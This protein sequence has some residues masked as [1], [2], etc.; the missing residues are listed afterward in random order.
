[1]NRTRYRLIFSRSRGQ[2]MA[3]AETAHAHGKAGQGERTGN[4]S[5]ASADARF[6]MRRIA[7]PIA[8][9]LC[10]TLGL[11]PVLAQIIADSNAPASQQPTVLGDARS[12]LVNIQTPSAAGVSRNTYSQFDV[13]P[14]GVVLNNSHYSNPWLMNGEARVILNEVNSSNPSYLRG[15]ITVNGVSAQ[16]VIAN[17]SGIQV[18]GASFVNA[19]RATLTTG[20]PIMNNGDLSGFSVRQGAVDISGRGLAAADTPYTEILSRAALIA[21]SVNARELNVTTGTQDIDYI[22]GKLTPVAGDGEPRPIAIDTAMLGGMYAGKI[23]LLATESGVGVR[24]AGT[25]SAL[26]GQIII[27]ADGQLQNTGS[28]RADVTSLATVSGNIDNSGTLSGEAMLL[29]AAAGDARFSG[30]QSN[31][32]G[33]VVLV[34]AGRDILFDS[35]VRVAGSGIGGQIQLDA[36]RNI[37]LAEDGEIVAPGNVSLNSG[38]TIT[39]RHSLV[40]SDMADVTVLA[41]GGIALEDST[42]RG[43][44]VHLETGAPFQETATDI[45]VRGGRIEGGQQATLIA[46]RD[47][48]LDAPD[49]VAVSADGDVALR[50]GGNLRMTAGSISTAG[51]DFTAIAGESLQMQGVAP[52]T[53][54][55]GQRAGISAIGNV[56][57]SGRGIDLPRGSVKAGGELAI[58]ATSADIRLGAPAHVYGATRDHLQLAAMGDLNISAY[59]GGITATTLD[60]QGKNIHVVS[61]GL[62]EFST[63]GDGRTGFKGG[64][65]FA[66]EDL[67]LGSISPD[68]PLSLTGTQLSAGGNIGLHSN[69]G[70]LI[71]N[72]QADTGGGLSGTA[73]H[74]GMTVTGTR[75]TAKGLL[76][77]ASSESQQHVFNTYDA[78]AM[79]LYTESGALGLYSSTLQTRVNQEAGLGDISGRLSLEAGGNFYFNSLARLTAA[80]DLSLVAGEGNL[81]IKPTNWSGGTLSTNQLSVGRDLTLAARHGDLVLDG[82]VG[83]NGGGIGVDLSVPRNLA[84]VGDNISMKGGRLFARTINLTATSGDIRIDAIPVASNQAGFDNTYWISPW[85]YGTF[86]IDLQAA[87]DIELNSVFARSHDTLSILSGGNLTTTGEYNRRNGIYDGWHKDEH[88]LARGMLYGNRGVTLGALGGHL[89]L[90]A[91]DVIAASGTARLQALGDIVLEAAQEHRLWQTQVDGRDCDAWSWFCESWTTYYHRETLT[92]QPVTVTARDIELKAGG[93]LDTYATRLNAGGNLTLEAGEAIHYYAVYDQQDN[94]ESR[95]SKSSLWGNSYSKSTESNSRSTLIGQAT[96][97][98]SQQ[99]ILSRS[100]GDQLLQGTQ[101]SYGGSA[102]FQAGVG[103]KPRADARILLEGLKN[104]VSEHRTLEYNAVLWQKQLDQGSVLETLVLP[105]FSGPGQPRFEAPG[106][107]AAQLPDASDFKAQIQ[108]LARQPGLAY[109]DGLTQRADVNWQAVKL[110]H[111][112][113]NYEQEGLTGAGAALL[114]VVVAWATAGLG[115]GANLIGA[116]EGTTA[117]LMADAAFTSLASQAAI[118]FVNN[119]GDLGKTLKD[120]GRSET[121]K[122][123]LAAMLT[124]GALSQIDGLGSV[125]DLKSSTAFGDQLT[126]NLIN[127]GGRAL[128]HTAIEGGDLEDALKQAILGAAVDTLHGEAASKIKTLEA[129]YLAH[130]LAH[131]LAGCVAGAAANGD[132]RDGAIGAAVGEV[133][134]ELMPPANGIAYSESE[135]DNVL[136]LSKLVAGATSAYAGGDAQTAITTAETAV[137]NNALIPVIVGLAW[138]ADKAWTAYEVSQDL[139]AIRDGT[140]TVAQVAQEKGEDYVTGIILGNIG[141]YGVKA[142]KVGGSWAQSKAVPEAKVLISQ[143]SRQIELLQMFDP[144]NARKGITVDNRSLLPRAG[145]AVPIYDGLS[146]KQ[147]QEYFKQL[148]G[149]ADLP[150]ARVIPGKGTIYQAKT[151]HG[152]FS[153]RDFADTASQSGPV[154]TIDFPRSMLP[155]NYKGSP[156]IK[157]GKM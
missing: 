43:G 141:R 91:T 152:N 140:K 22:T 7:K 111:D 157:F 31:N 63:A 108:T 80:T 92:A 128:T 54:D 106:G 121:V 148:T 75:L 116:T 16:V 115:A 104:S 138:L 110:A 142:V 52:D 90:N 102:T 94:A 34:S 24:N 77:L 139:A 62:T 112:Q 126:Y 49:A 103:D 32:Q 86:G 66:L 20:T 131:A 40:T 67:T 119:K 61:N 154:W 84:L 13:E 105:R 129:D 136:A 50:A 39:L 101:V 118:S 97:L 123:T 70:L 147:V 95:T 151:E 144:N 107:L 29:V 83:A 71:A 155:P 53:P 8:V 113:W 82:G 146:E 78:G 122:A 109:L 19:T 114:A 59:Q 1:M 58:E 137:R 60:A 134:A 36:S 69:G 12:P 44:R 15:P 124:A 41:I 88:T 143:Q 38:G 149:Q 5:P 65:L 98:Q 74:G 30:G 51:G 64:S 96:Q 55:N 156:E 18:D 21:G 73:S 153:L 89:T 79:S 25:L 145:Q 100:G 127:A 6:G 28:I 33:R 133:V 99:D 9:L 132:C 120:L 14:G 11:N 135:K 150:V 56:L 76:D 17:P 35:H 68:Q 27:T 23:T 42:V 57:L 117:A 47:L 46:T 130:K 37:D 45:L 26:N 4:D 2:L 48:L 72:V 3:V 81:T 87:R 85:L 10:L 125:K 93:N